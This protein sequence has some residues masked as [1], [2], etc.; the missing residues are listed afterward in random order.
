MDC[1][2]NAGG[3]TVYFVCWLFAFTSYLPLWVQELTHSAFFLPSLT[4][5]FIPS[6]SHAIKTSYRV[7]AGKKARLLNC[8]HHCLFL[9]LGPWTSLRTA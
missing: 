6:C 8:I 4:H 3:I 2:Q 5:S 1:F 9:T 7:E